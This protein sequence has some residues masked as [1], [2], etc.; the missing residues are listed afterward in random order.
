VKTCSAETLWLDPARIR[1]KI[2]PVADLHGIVAGEWDRERAFALDGAIKHRAIAQRYRDG[3]PWEE[4]DLF[5]EAYARR[6]AAGE[7]V[8]G[9]ATM[10]ALLD[11]YYT[12]VDRMFDDMKF[13]GF[14]IW[15][16]SRNYPLPTLLL[17]RG[18]IFI[19]NQ[20]N[21]RLAMAQVLGLAKFAGKVTCRHQLA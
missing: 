12:R 2:S 19:G 1:F 21:H 17:G 10:Q 20:G 6:L 15:D 14:Q 9:A 18:E 16:G 8:R 3:R 11:Q 4:T 7:P 13:R 5:R